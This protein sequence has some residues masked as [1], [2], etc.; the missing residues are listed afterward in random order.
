M[1]DYEGAEYWYRRNSPK[2]WI[3]FD[4]MIATHPIKRR[5]DWGVLDPRLIDR[6]I[7][8]ISVLEHMIESQ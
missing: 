8:S 4:S 7:P 2:S 3:Q 6:F 1:A 5:E